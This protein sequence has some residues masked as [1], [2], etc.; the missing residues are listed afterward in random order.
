MLE[1]G[2]VITAL[3]PGHQ[4]SPQRVQEIA[5]LQSKERLSAGIQ[6][7]ALL[8]LMKPGVWSFPE[9]SPLGPGSHAL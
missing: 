2:P 7:P 3:R 6:D 4:L 9:S 5:G 1:P 8:A